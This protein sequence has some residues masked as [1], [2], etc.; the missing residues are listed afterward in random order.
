MDVLGEKSKANTLMAEMKIR[1]QELQLHIGQGHLVQGKCL[2]H[3]L[4]FMRSSLS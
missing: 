1:R 4:Q 3:Q 2:I